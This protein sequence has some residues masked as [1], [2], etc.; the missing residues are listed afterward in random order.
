MFV[1]MLLLLSRFSRVLLCATPWT[2][3]LLLVPLQSSCLENPMDY[4]PWGPKESDTTKLV[5]SLSNVCLYMGS[6][7]SPTSFFFQD[8][9][10]W[11]F[12]GSL[13]VH[14]KFRMNFS[15][16]AKKKG[17]REFN[18]NCIVCRSLRVVLT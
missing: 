4:I 5:L 7:R 14:M 12:R 10:G 6:M 2:T 13:R 9:F 11:L 8:G 1:S 17:H 15:K 3:T 18:R 16:S